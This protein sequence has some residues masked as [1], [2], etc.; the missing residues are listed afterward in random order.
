M[1]EKDP[2]SDKKK[3]E[4]VEGKTNQQNEVNPELRGE[5]MTGAEEEARPSGRTVATEDKSKRDTNT[6]KGEDV[7]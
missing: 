2:Y 7:E 1:S 3:N 6:T 5:N 4:T